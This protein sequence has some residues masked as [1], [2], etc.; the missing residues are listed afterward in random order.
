MEYDGGVDKLFVFK[1]TGGTTAF[2]GNR[3]GFNT[4]APQTTLHVIGNRIRLGDDAKRIDL[5]ADGADVDLHTPTHHLWIRTGGNPGKRHVFIN[6]DNASEGNVGIGTTG[7]TSKLD[8]NGDLRVRNYAYKDTPGSFWLASDLALK[9]D[10]T[11]LSGA[12][13]HLLK[14]RGVEF[15]WREPEKHGATTDRYKGFI[16]QE[17]EKVFPQWVMTTPDGT[18]ALNPIGLEALVVEALRELNAKCTKLEAE[19]KSLRERG[20]PKPAGEPEKK[21]ADPSAPPAGRGSPRRGTKA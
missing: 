16:A 2:M 15:S 13:E 7:P 3:F 11:P 10:V 21:P 17:V 20:G 12:L 6:P 19:I 5:R 14:L 4:A 9:K 18:K 8:V 1:D